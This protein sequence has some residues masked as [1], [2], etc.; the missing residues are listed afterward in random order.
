MESFELG[1]ACPEK[2][3]DF[4]GHGNPDGTCWF[5]GM[6]ESI[7]ESVHTLEQNLAIRLKHFEP[8]MDLH[9]SVRLLG[10]PISQRDRP[11]TPVWPW[12]AKIIR[13]LVHREVDWF[14]PDQARRYVAERLGKVDEA[15]FLAELL[16]LPRAK[17][18]QWQ[19]PDSRWWSTPRLYEEEIVPRRIQMLRSLMSRH[20]PRWV[21]AYG[22]RHHDRYK[23]VF[24][25][26]R[27]EVIDRLTIGKADVVPRFVA[28]VPFLGNGQ[29]GCSDVESLVNSAQD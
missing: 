25:D 29:F 19:H 21:I 24:S 15:C 12:M 27:W 23:E 22:R 8:I 9:E 7:D 28:L 1:R 10:R 16:P 5:L 20:Q 11:K 14:D 26:R 2:L 3:L 13:A 6:E 17:D 18:G 4:L